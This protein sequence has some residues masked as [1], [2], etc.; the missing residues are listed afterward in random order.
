MGSYSFLC[1]AMHSIRSSLQG[2]TPIAT[3]DQEA[4][5]DQQHPNFAFPLDD[6]TGM[7]NMRTIEDLQ[8]IMCELPADFKG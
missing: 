1:I 3:L 4:E 5:D 6:N 2:Y 8:D 7:S